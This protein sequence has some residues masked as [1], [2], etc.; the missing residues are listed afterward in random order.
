MCIWVAPR[1]LGVPLCFHRGSVSGCSL[2]NLL[3]HPSLSLLPSGSLQS[4]T[5][6]QMAEMGSVNAP[7]R[8]GERSE[9]RRSRACGYISW[10]TLARVFHWPRPAQWLS[11]PVAWLHQTE[12]LKQMEAGVSSWGL[13]KHCSRA[14]CHA[15]LQAQS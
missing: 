15:A 10:E 1:G 11:I 5:G 3:H 2:S 14:S 12:R 4:R 13:T 6:P 9:V 8:R 7:R